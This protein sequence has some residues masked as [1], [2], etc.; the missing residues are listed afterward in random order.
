MHYLLQQSSNLVSSNAVTF[1][2]TIHPD[3]DDSMLLKGSPSSLLRVIAGLLND[4]HLKTITLTPRFK[5]TTF[6]RS[7]NDIKLTPSTELE[8]GSDK[9]M[10]TT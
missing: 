10:L 6:L 5:P 7:S 9:R 2:S 8:T 4:N 3:R 1:T